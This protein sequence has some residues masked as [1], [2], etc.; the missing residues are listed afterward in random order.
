M[1]VSG[2]TI[3]LLGATVAASAPAPAQEPSKSK[4]AAESRWE[5]TIQGFEKQ[6]EQTPVPANATVFVG[7]SSIRMWNL[8]KHFPDRQAVN[9]GFG[10]SQFS[11]AIQ[12]VD[13]IVT[14]YKPANVVIYEGDN[15]LAKGKSPE[16]VT[17]DFVAFTSRIR[18]K[19]PKARIFVIA[20]KPSIK[21]WSLADDIQKTNRQIAQKCDE[22]PNMVFVD[23]FKPML[24]ADGKPRKELFIKDGLHMNEVGYKEWTALINQALATPR[25]RSPR[26]TSTRELGIDE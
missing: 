9:R 1:K 12:Y 22:D 11:D 13:R 17:R 3:L 16:V 4:P 21:R 20:V 8:K 2:I 18:K 19:L 23:V 6:A 25:G 7:S 5:K 24:D 14:N 15:D 10:G 26:T